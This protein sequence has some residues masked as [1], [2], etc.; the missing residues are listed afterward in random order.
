MRVPIFLSCENYILHLTAKK[1]WS[2][3]KRKIQVSAVLLELNFMVQLVPACLCPTIS[4]S[5]SLEI[6][7]CMP[8]LTET[9]VIRST[10]CI[11]PLE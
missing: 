2:V 11:F 4:Q 8:T 5:K 6:F 1:K 10:F 9:I 7:I 3:V